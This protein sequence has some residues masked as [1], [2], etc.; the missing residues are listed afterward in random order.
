MLGFKCLT[1][2][3]FGRLLKHLLE[4]SGIN[5]TVAAGVLSIIPLKNE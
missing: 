3:G 5:E 2:D 4:E 1:Q